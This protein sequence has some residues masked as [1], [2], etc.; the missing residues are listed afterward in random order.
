MEFEKE[1]V[2]Q[3]ILLKNSY[4]K[5]CGKVKYTGN[6]SN[7]WTLEEGFLTSILFYRKIHFNSYKK[8]KKL[9]RETG[10]SVSLSFWNG[11]IANFNPQSVPGS[12]QF[13]SIIRVPPG[14]AL[15]FAT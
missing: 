9:T 6:C 8:K 10:I 1:E 15:N 12:W 4:R 3:S 5:F 7:P 2:F 11:A 13:V 14:G